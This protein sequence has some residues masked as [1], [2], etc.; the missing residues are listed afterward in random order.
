MATTGAE[1]ADLATGAASTAT[2][3]EKSQLTRSRVRAP[4]Y[5]LDRGLLACSQRAIQGMRFAAT[6]APTIVTVPF[7]VR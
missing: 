7:Q 6:G 1:V 4:Q 2:Q 5:L 3:V